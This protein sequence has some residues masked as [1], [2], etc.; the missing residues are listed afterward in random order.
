MLLI[1]LN[2]CIAGIY[3]ECWCLLEV[4]WDCCRSLIWSVARTRTACN[5]EDK[6]G[7]ISAEGAGT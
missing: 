3:Y 7:L 4:L 2:I 1:I 6:T 5:M